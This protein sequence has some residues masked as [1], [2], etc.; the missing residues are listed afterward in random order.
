LPPVD[1]HL[2]SALPVL[3]LGHEIPGCG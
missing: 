1:H 3:R 2:P